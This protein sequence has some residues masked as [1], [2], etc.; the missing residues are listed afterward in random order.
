MNSIPIH[1]PHTGLGACPDV[2]RCTANYC[3][4]T[5]FRR[6]ESGPLCPYLIATQQPYETPCF[7][8]A[9]D[10]ATYRRVRALLPAVLSGN[11]W[12]RTRLSLIKPVVARLYLRRLS[13]C[14]VE[15]L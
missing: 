11:G 14:H 13:A 12:L 10:S 9:Q 8:N 4:L 15:V 5:P 2:G 3:P 1:L 7:R 6:Q